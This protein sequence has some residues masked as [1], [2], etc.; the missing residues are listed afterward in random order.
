MPI[1]CHY[2]PQ[3]YLKYFLQD[4]T[5]LLWVYDKKDISVRQQRP[6]NTAVIGDFYVSEKDDLGNKDARVEKCLSKIEGLISPV[7]EEIIRNP[8]H[9]NI[10]DKEAIALFLSIMHCRIPRTVQIIR[11]FH[12]ALLDK[13]SE[14]IAKTKTNKE[15]EDDY[16][17]F[18]AK[19]NVIS[20]EEFVDWN[21]NPKKHFSYII[22][23][24]HMLD[25]SFK[26]IDTFYAHL[27]S[28]NWCICSIKGN[29]FFITC[30]APLN[31][32]SLNSLR[33]SYFGTGF[34]LQNVEVVF[35]LTP[36][37]CIRMRHTP[38][39]L[40]EKIESAYVNAINQR[41]IYMAEQ[42]I[43]STYKSNRILKFIKNYANTYKAPKV[44]KEE[45]K[46]K[47]RFGNE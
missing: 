42:Y 46:K 23:E 15:I 30:D 19:D 25:F 22:N 45:I 29:N 11:E 6:I 17:R 39:P 7:L 21:R 32:F 34:G 5:D 35:P 13:A 12:E 47:I 36:K 43:F 44:N 41:S 18:F 20:F 2:I 14:H 38:L 26:H 31:V 33:Q 16:K 28:M 40:F 24:K 10:R 3:F 37:L 1:R 9:W 27:K 8:T 4:T